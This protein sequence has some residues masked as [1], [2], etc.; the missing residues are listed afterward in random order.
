MTEEEIEKICEDIQ[1]ICFVLD[2]IG[3]GL[4]LLMLCVRWCI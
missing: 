1:L 4:G 3:I 2:I